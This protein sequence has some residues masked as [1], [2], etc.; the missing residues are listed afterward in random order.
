MDLIL[1]IIL[2]T[3]FFILSA[4]HIYWGFGGRVAMA[5][6]F[7]TKED[8]TSLAK[9]PGIMASFVVAVGLF[10]F[11]LFYLLKGKLL[12]NVL[13]CYINEYGYWVIGF[14]FSLRALG[15]FKYVGLFKKIKATPFGIKDT[16]IYTPLCIFISCLTFL[17]LLLD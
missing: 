2:A 7:P 8:G 15:D 5:D 11:G 3:V 16:N 12:S 1:S 10:F 4:I 6:A 13:P 17:L 9:V 14:M